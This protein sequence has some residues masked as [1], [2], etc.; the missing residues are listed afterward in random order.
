MPAPVASA[1]A[2]DGQPVITYPTSVP[3]TEV[4]LQGNGFPGNWDHNQDLAHNYPSGYIGDCDSAAGQPS[5]SNPCRMDGFDLS[6]TG[7]DGEGHPTCTYTYQYVNPKDIAPYWTLAQEYALAD[8]A[9]MTQG[10]ESFT[11]HQDLIAGGTAGIV[12]NAS[13]IDDPTGF[14]WGCDG[15]PSGE[16]TNLITIYGQYLADKGP[17][18]CWNYPNGTIRDE[19]DAAGISWKYYANK[20]Y[21]YTQRSE[22]RRLR[23]LERFRCGPKRALQ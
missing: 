1:C 18:P 6:N 15:N 23:H 21:P 20:A 19:L 16:K 22:G 9:F 14:P 17:F 7:P 3:L 2:E 12:T 10:S 11:A 5:G 4:D 8:N 13:I